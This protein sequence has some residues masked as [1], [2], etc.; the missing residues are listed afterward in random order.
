MTNYQAYNDLKDV[1]KLEEDNLVTATE[2][3]ER[4]KSMFKYGTINSLDL[5]Q[6]QINLLATEQRIVNLKHEIKTYE[7]MLLMLSGQLRGE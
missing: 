3:F 2:N 1:L 4:S 7:T 6:S 5:R